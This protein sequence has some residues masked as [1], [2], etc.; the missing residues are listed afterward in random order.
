[1]SSKKKKILSA[2]LASSMLMSQVS[3]VAFAEA[4]NPTADMLNFSLEETT[5]DGTEKSI[6][7]SV[8][9]EQPYS[10]TL[11]VTE[12]KYSTTSQDTGEYPEGATDAPINVGTYYVYAKISSTDTGTYKTDYVVN[13]GSF[14]IKAKELKST[15]LEF[16][17]TS[18]FTKTYD[19]NT[20]CST[21]SAQIKAG[22]V[23]EEAVSIE[24]TAAYD[25]ANVKDVTK[26]TFTPT[27]ITS[28][29]YTLAA[30]ETIEN[31]ATITA[32]EISKIEISDVALP[33]GGSE[34]DTSAADTS[35]SG[36]TISTV[37]WKPSGTAGYN[38]SYTATVTATPDANHVFKDGGVTITFNS[39]DA[40]SSKK[41]EDGSYTITKTFTT[42]KESVSD[43]TL[44][45]VDAPVAGANVPTIGVDSGANGKYSIEST[46]WYT[47]GE[48][49]TAFNDKTFGANTT[50]KV[51][52]VLAPGENCKFA[53][54]VNVSGVDGVSSVA[55]D[56]ESGKVTIEKTFAQT[57]ELTPTYTA[58]EAKNLTYRGRAQSLV[59]TGS[60]TGGTFKYR[61]GETGEFGDDIPT[62]TDAGN[63]KVYYKIVGNDGYADIDTPEPAFIEV[64]IA[65]AEVTNFEAPTASR[66]LNYGD[67]LSTAGLTSGWTWTDG[68][69]K[70]GVG[71]SKFTATYT[72]SEEDDKNYDYAAFAQANGY[73]Y[74]DKTLTANV[75]VKVDKKTL[76]SL[77]VDA[78]G[79][80]PFLYSG[81]AKTFDSVKISYSDINLTENTD[82]TIKYENNILVGDNTAKLIISPVESSNY[83]FEP[84]TYT[85]S[86]LKAT[87]TIYTEYSEQG[88][89]EGS[90]EF[91]V[92]TISVPGTVEYKVD[93]AK[94][95]E[96]EFRAF[97]KKQTASEEPITVT[98]TLIPDDTAN[99]NTH[100]IEIKFTIVN[101]VFKI[102]DNTPVSAENPAVTIDESKLVYGYSWNDILKTNVTAAVLGNDKNTTGFS[103][104]ISDTIDSAGKHSYEYFFSGQIG[105]TQ[106]NHIVVSK[107]TFDIAP[108]PITVSAGSTACVSKKYDKTTTA[109]T[110]ICDIT[111]YFTINGLVSGDEGKVSVKVESIGDYKDA[112][113]TDSDTVDVVVSLTGEAAGNYTLG[114]N[115][116]VSGVTAK[117]TQRTITPG[118]EVTGKFNYTGS[119]PSFTA[120]DIVVTFTDEAI[121]NGAKQTLTFGTD[122]T[123][124]CTSVNAGSATAKIKKVAGSNFTFD[125]KDVTFTIGA[126]DL[127]VEYAEQKTAGV[128]SGTYGAK[129]S[130]LTTF[131]GLTVKIAGTDTPVNGTWKITGAGS[132]AVPNVGDDGTYT[133][134]FTPGTTATN[135]NTLTA[136][137]TLDISKATLPA[138]L[139]VADTAVSLNKDNTSEQ[140]VK[141]T[142]PAVDGIEYKSIAITS[143]KNSII[144][145]NP[146]SY[147][148]DGSVTFTIESGKSKDD[149]ATITVTFTSTN[150]SDFDV[151]LVITL[152]DLQDQAAP[153]A[154]TLTSELEAGGNTYKVTITA[155]DTVDNE[156]T[157]EYSFDGITFS[158]KYET[159]GVAPNTT[160][161]GY[162]RYAK[163][164]TSNA[165]PAVSATITTPM[166]ASTEPT[167]PTSEGEFEDSKVITISA[168][169]G[170][171]IYYTLDGSTPTENSTLYTA[172]FTI[173]DTTTV[174]AIAVNYG[175]AP[176]SVVEATYTK[177]ADPV[178]PVT[179]YTV[180]FSNA[181]VKNGTTTLTSGDKVVAGTKLTVTAI[182][183]SGK[184][185]TLYINGKAVTGTSTTITVNANVK[186]TV[187]YTT[188]SSG[189]NPGGTGGSGGGSSGGSSS[190]NTSPSV[191]G[192]TQTWSDIAKDIAKL[193]ADKTETISLN[194]ST[195]VPVDVVKAIATSNAE[196]TLKVNNVFSWTIDGS[197][198]DP[199]D[200]KAADLSITTTTVTGTNVLRG[201]VGTGFTIKGTNVKSELNI[202]FK[203]TNAGKFAN[204]FKKVD[205]KLVFVDN[206]KVDEKGAAIGL[207]VSEKGEYVVMLGDFSDR[208]GDMD[209]DGVMNANDALAVIK[210]FLEIEA[211]A[212]PLVADVNHDGRINAKDSLQIIIEFLNLE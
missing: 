46:T 193:P 47:V 113:V 202:N 108:K 30:S 43:V 24:G 186:I 75:S 63:Y 34:L 50:Y 73:T 208:S 163:D 166:A 52:I 115:T 53:G 153:D 140:S 31:S 154:P 175:K 146:A 210:D 129:L 178:V 133:A 110:D 83:T 141:I 32:A 100:S 161:T 204:L 60:V 147:K 199:K 181:T 189:N 212:N 95:S 84:Y 179:E 172:P 27:A 16:T 152:S 142:L 21:V 6:S 117:I 174:K 159:T 89:L 71:N 5:Y 39:G 211:G 48:E 80:T 85:F 124:E 72:V 22:V 11:S 121:E 19:G 87:P 37:S 136:K 194:G 156:K 17:S 61:L 58:P 23:G 77:K 45:G 38:K 1:M 97:L 7:V 10:E 69:T 8:K 198:I 184:T 78:T 101:I 114:E 2:L 62:A 12:V 158:S 79:S 203:A 170:A 41:N 160:V 130:E 91:S 54:S 195:T 76:P 182:P 149:T 93:E 82:F 197:E 157:L 112:D 35:A 104:D 3:V 36:Y 205:G 188:N 66:T 162:I 92:P 191:D 29:N 155:P 139:T 126:A 183:Q 209:N 177:K 118:A 20:T 99:Y 106:F 176:S 171:K 127:S 173:T 187:T 150:Y 18:T 192:K 207:E 107:G 116:T 123:V 103:L 64:T 143:D 96:S 145:G 120:D 148:E 164:T 55:P 28:G 44:T 74:T 13:L 111:N 4:T 25:N 94:Y 200:A 125:D 144:S 180:T 40:T 56:G 132:D 165:S 51:V 15:D 196:V 185:A 134:T 168:D 190:I 57:G 65:Q 109:N 131:S 9:P 102:D 49:E 67:T 81:E 169:E 201:I 138:N 167:L 151:K 105:E 135:Y 68:S 59:A 206:V 122:F 128:A 14:E 42:E 26:I 137:V 90:D 98:C 119:A 88:V 33:T 86:I 70:P